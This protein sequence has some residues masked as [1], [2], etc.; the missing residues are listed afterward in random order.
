MLEIHMNEAEIAIAN[1][2]IHNMRA[3][4]IIDKTSGIK[5]IVPLDRLAAIKVGQ[6]LSSGLAVPENLYKEN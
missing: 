4:I 3:V 6:A 5:V 1:D 2:A